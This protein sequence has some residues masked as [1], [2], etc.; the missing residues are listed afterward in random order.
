MGT[1]DQQVFAVNGHCFHLDLLELKNYNYSA[2]TYHIELGHFLGGATTEKVEYA[3]LC[4][5]GAHFLLR[6]EIERHLLFSLKNTFLPPFFEIVFT[7]NF[8]RI[9]PFKVDHDLRSRVF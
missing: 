4:P 1:H 9:C 7:V 3:K 5:D 8:P 6:E 2:G